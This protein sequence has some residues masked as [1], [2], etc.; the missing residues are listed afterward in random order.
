MS[1][2]LI[3]LGDSI[4]RWGARWVARL[5]RWLLRVWGWRVAGEFPNHPRMVVI[6]APHS[7]NWDWPVGMLVVL[8]LR[9]RAHWI[10]KDTLF[11]GPFG[12]IFKWLGGIPVDRSAP[13]GVVETM[14]SSMLAQEQYLLAIAPEGTRSRVN[15]FKSGF[16]RIARGAGVPIL[17]VAFNHATK[18][19]NF[20]PP[21]WPSG[22]REGD[23]DQLQALLAKHGRRRDQRQLG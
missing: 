19:V 7:S 17:P 20:L 5:S 10:G 11:R 14:V 12:A 13:G 3:P 22:D 2:N 18:T 6:V 1:E 9:V 21:F 15:R 16:Y 8:A 23:I 4:P